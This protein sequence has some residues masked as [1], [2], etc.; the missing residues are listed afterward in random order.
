MKFTEFAQKIKPIIG[1]SYSTHVF[2]RTLFESIITEDGLL[3]IEDISENTFKAYYNGQTKITKISQRILPHIEPEQFIAYLDGF[4]DATTQRL[5]DTFKSD[6]EDINL[7]N[8]TEKI[9]YYFER[10]LTAAATQKRKPANKKSN[11]ATLSERINNQISVADKALADAGDNAIE[12]LVD[13][14]DEKIN[15][16]ATS[17]Q[18]PEEQADES[19]YSSEDNLLLKEFT[20]DY[21]EIMTILI[22][23]NYAASLIDMTLPCKIKDLYENKCRS[24][25]DKFAN[26]SLKSY[27]FGLLGELKNISNSFLDGSSATLFFGSARAK[28]RNLYVKLHPNQFTG[29]FPYDAFIDD[30][31]DG[32]F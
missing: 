18:I 32:E 7:Y 23:E 12:K 31:D 28:I 24:K 19:P 4:P 2:T 9:A 5:C 30:W 11:G 10:I 8:A 13:E 15:Q 6:I 26:P 16:E 25:A 14:L 29:N 20:A 3:Q 27:V 1:G 21:D 17:I 22:G